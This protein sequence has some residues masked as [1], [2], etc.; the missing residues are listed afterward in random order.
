MVNHV[1]TLLLNMS[2][3]TAGTTPGEELVPTAYRPV[4][5]PGALQR[6]STALFGAGA[7]RAGKNLQLARILGYLHAS[8][9]ADYVTAADARLTYHPDRV[10]TVFDRLGTTV[11]MLSGAESTGLAGAAEFAVPGRAHGSWVVTTDGAGGYTVAGTG[12]QDA[13]GSVAPSD[14]G[15]AVPLPG[16]RLS[17]VVVTGGAGSWR[18]ALTVPP[19]HNFTAVVETGD[20]GAVFRPARS[21]AEAAWLGAWDGSPVVALRAGAFALALAA[22]TQDVIDGVNY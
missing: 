7:D 10:T 18:V 21:G 3:E 4:T 20:P 8:P 1:R 22:R 11:T 5:L 19:P 17:L 16:S 15:D 12:V 6:A 14:L 2:A 13:Q 9:L